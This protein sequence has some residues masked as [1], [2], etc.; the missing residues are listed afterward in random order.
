[1]V[2]LWYVATNYLKKGLKYAHIDSWIM[3]MEMIEGTFEDGLKDLFLGGGFHPL[4]IFKI[5]VRR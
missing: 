3:Q 1:M 4:T 2:Q 5:D